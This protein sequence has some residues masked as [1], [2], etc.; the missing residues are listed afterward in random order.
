M[1]LLENEVFAHHQLLS[2]VEA[3]RGETFEETLPVASFNDMFIALK[4]FSS[5][6]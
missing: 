6:R 2:D 1:A 5:A 3:K 4:L